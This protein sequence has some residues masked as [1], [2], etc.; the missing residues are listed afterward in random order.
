MLF[1]GRNATVD[2]LKEKANHFLGR[3]TVQPNPDSSASSM[4]L[5]VNQAQFINFNRF[6]FINL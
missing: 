5:G 2:S 3:C 4:E 6:E 1:I